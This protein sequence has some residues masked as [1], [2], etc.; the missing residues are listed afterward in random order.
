M[1]A[2]AEVNSYYALSH[3][4]GNPGQTPSPT[5]GHLS[6]NNYHH[7]SVNHHPHHHPNQH[8]QQQQSTYF[9]QSHMQDQEQQQ[10]QQQQH[11]ATNNNTSLTTVSDNSNNNSYNMHSNSVEGGIMTMNHGEFMGHHN[12]SHYNQHMSQDLSNHNNHLPHQRF[13]GPGGPMPHHPWGYGPH[14]NQSWHDEQDKSVV[15]YDDYDKPLA[16]RP[17]KS[18][19]SASPKRRGRKPKYIKLMENG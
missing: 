18:K 4:N 9:N 17:R 2:E 19:Q 14:D 11:S 16:R 6:H 8:Q 15:N 13:P 12:N 1:R 3:Y 5:L 7:S 10:Q